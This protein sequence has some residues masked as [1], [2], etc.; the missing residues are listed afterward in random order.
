M[1]NFCYCLKYNPMKRWSFSGKKII[2]SKFSPAFKPRAGR[3]KFPSYLKWGGGNETRSH[4]RFATFSPF[5]SWSYFSMWLLRG[6]SFKLTLST[7]QPQAYLN[8][9]YIRHFLV[10]A[11]CETCNRTQSTQSKIF[12]KSKVFNCVYIKTLQETFNN[13]IPSWILHGTKICRKWTLYFINF[14]RAPSVLTFEKYYET[15]LHMMI[16]CTL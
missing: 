1:S 14:N 12:Q 7:G 5:C 6:Q 11:C 13:Y 15:S 16:L 10:L 2:S 4:W 8:K 3:Q 9:T